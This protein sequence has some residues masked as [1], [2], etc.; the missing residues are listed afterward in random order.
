M[1]I[2][3]LIRAYSSAVECVHGMDEVRVRLPVGPRAEREELSKATACLASGR[4]RGFAC[5]SES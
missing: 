1:V 2:V 3:K 5:R 4:R